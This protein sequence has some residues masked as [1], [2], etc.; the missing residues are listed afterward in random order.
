M[1]FSDIQGWLVSA[2]DAV[3]LMR[4]VV[5]LLPKGEKRTEIESKIAAAENTLARSDA[6]L[7]R[8]LGLKLC[9]CTFPPQIMLWKEAQKA[10]VCPNADCGRVTKRGMQISQEAVDQVSRP[11]GPNSW[12]A[13]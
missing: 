8:E 3:G 5:E 1:D 13:R 11:S 6:K 12:M 4:S 7:A 2:K 10:H 9:D